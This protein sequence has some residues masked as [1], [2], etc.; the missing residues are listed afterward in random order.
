MPTNAIGANSANITYNG[1]AANAAWHELGGTGQVP[2]EDQG[3]VGI[4]GR[5]R[6]LAR[7]QSHH[8]SNFGVLS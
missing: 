4:L 8:V 2:V 7:I 5:R 1:P 3:G 6:D